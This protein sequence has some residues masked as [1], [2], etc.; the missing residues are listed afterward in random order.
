[1]QSRLNG[2]GRRRRSHG[3]PGLDHAKIWLSGLIWLGPHKN[4]T[5]INLNPRM[6]AALWAYKMFQIARSPG[7]PPNPTERAYSASQIPGW[8]EGEHPLPKNPTLLGSLSFAVRPSPF[9]W[10]LT[11]V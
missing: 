7:F 2:W 10:I 11:T 6:G 1:M 4:F 5:E 3:G 9:L 8:Q